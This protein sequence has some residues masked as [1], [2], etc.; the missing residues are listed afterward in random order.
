MKPACWLL[1]AAFISTAVR[2]DISTT[3]SPS[4]NG[5]SQSLE[6]ASTGKQTNL[7][8]R[9]FDLPEM[10]Y[11]APAD[12][13][14]LPP[15]LTRATPTSVAELQSIQKHVEALVA[16]VSPTVVA[17]EI[18]NGSGSG[19]II[20]PD[21][22]VL[23]AGHVCGA[24]NR[25]VVFTFPDGKTARGKTLG[26]N[27]VDDIGLMKIDGKGPWTNAAMGE[28]EDAH[29]GDWVLALGH[30][31]G[32]D[33]TRSL[34]VRLGR[35]IRVSTDMLQSDC[36]ISPGDSGGPLF[37]MYGRVI[38]IHS[39]IST[40]M[41][42]NFHVAVTPCYD[43]WAQLV[44][45]LTGTAPRAY[46]GL[47]E[48]SDG[49]CRIA[50]VDTNGPAFTAGLKIGDIVLKVDGRDLLAAASFRH[51]EAESKPGET[52]RLEIKRGDK[53]LSMDLALASPPRRRR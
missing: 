48:V 52:L 23:T 45:G 35:L 9:A 20:T 34:V 44:A 2:A 15:A 7:Y 25:N 26:V 3:N 41:T 32:F 14:K 12:R 27:S 10:P 19:V 24:P 17:V 50:A 21:G 49:G 6:P 1:V 38:G 37:D 31:G 33:A 4:T 22:Y 39:F 47:V 18:G 36:P 8:P 51:W 29:I 30:P 46:A 28:V 13:K 42:A 11:T 5:I 16:R 53:V 40:S 43:G